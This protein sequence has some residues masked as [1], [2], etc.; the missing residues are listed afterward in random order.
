VVRRI[1]CPVDISAG[2]TPLDVQVTSSGHSDRV[3]E[4]AKPQLRSL[5]RF[6]SSQSLPGLS[7]EMP[8]MLG[9]IISDFSTVSTGCRRLTVPISV[10]VSL[11]SNLRRHGQ[12]LSE[13][14]Q[15][16]CT[17]KAQWFTRRT[18]TTG[19]SAVES[20]VRSDR[21]SSQQYSLPLP[22]LYRSSTESS[23]FTTMV[24]VDL[25]LPESMSTPTISTKLLDV[26]YTLDLTI[27]VEASGNDSLK[28][29]Y[30]ASFSLP[31]ALRAASPNSM[32][33]RRSVDPVLGFVEEQSLF[34][35]PPYVY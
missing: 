12:S 6:L 14:D 11:P 25:L 1:S 35:P 17:V 13:K 19:S 22:P 26:S 28:S 3:E 29:P 16:R 10:N 30:V 8:K 4:T 9:S 18:F 33:S 2:L 21:V 24:E 31:L 5:N 23:K 34:A 32:I 7:I 27:K 15:L 20:T